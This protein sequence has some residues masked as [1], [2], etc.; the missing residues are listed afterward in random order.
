[1]KRVLRLTAMLL[2][3]T[4]A[5]AFPA[6]AAEPRSSA[7]ISNY[8]TGIVVEGKGQL[9]IYF[10][11]TST[12]ADMLQ[13]GASVVEVY[14][15]DGTWVQSFRCSLVEGM[16]AYNTFYMKSHVTFYG[17]P[18]TEYYARVVFYAKG[19]TGSDSR[20]AFTTPKVA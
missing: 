10:T 19:E 13:L 14:K 15:A 6:L 12:G 4:L 1:M 3:L 5:L 8:S 11:I 7:Y 18:G 9:D 20:V 17:V 2:A 16:M